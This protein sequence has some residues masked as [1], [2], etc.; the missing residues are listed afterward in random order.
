MRTTYYFSC[1]A[2]N[3]PTGQDRS[4]LTELLKEAAVSC[5][6]SYTPCPPLQAQILSRSIPGKIVKASQ[7]CFSQFGSIY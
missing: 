3:I 2:G 5:G 4:L 6:S 1:L 7:K